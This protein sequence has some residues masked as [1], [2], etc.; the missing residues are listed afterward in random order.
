MSVKLKNGWTRTKIMNRIKKYNY[1]RVAKNSDAFSCSYLTNDGNRCVIGAFIPDKHAGL[2]SS[3]SV[4]GLLDSYPDLRKYM[5]S[6]DLAFLTMLQVTH[7]R[8][9][10]RSEVYPKIKEFLDD[11]IFIR[12]K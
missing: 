3:K 9:G 1:N 10:K 2:E 6:S 11:C 5:P 7:D 12:T 8:I 4:R